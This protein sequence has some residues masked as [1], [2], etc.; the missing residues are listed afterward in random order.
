MVKTRLLAA[1]SVAV[2]GCL[3]CSRAAADDTGIYV[4]VN[5]GKLLS[6]YR[7]TDIDGNLIGILGGSNNGAELGTS[8]VRKDHVAWTADVG[9]MLSQNFGVEASFINLGALKYSSYGT[10]LGSEYSVAFDMKTHGPALAGVAVLPMSNLWEVDAHAGAFFAKTVANYDS[11]LG[12]PGSASK[13]STSLLVGAGTGFTLTSH[14]TL[15]LD[16]LRLESIKEGVLN[17][18]FNVDLVTMGV[19]FVF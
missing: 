16:Y 11:S 5:A 14:C 15:R 8:S 4:G 1:T 10:D 9:Y 19:A 18:K 3:A 13:S 17:G 7:R 6:S 2:I 12:T